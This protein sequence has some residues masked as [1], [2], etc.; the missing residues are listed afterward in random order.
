MVFILVQIG[1]IIIQQF[2]DGNIGTLLPTYLI[3][4]EK[5]NKTMFFNTAQNEGGI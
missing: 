3:K 4:K 1:V 2:W 5:K